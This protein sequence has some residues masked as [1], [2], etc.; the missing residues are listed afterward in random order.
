MRIGDLSTVSGVSAQTIRFYERRGLMAAS[1]RDSN[2]YRRYD[3]AAVT[4]LRFI[5]SAQRAGL[6]LYEV[7]SIISIR[8]Q[9][10]A[11]CEHASSLL[12]AKLAEVRRRQQELLLLERELKTLLAKHGTHSTLAKANAPTP[13]RPAMSR[14]GVG[15]VLRAHPGREF[16]AP[17]GSDGRSRTP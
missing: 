13:P 16:V 6:T 12:Q 4:R 7:A 10:N 2:G 14:C 5:R 17:S 3:D 11:P 9:G 1:V 15:F 8:E